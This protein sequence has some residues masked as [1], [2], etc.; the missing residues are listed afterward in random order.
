MELNYLREFIVLSET[1]NFLAASE[2]LFIS[3]STLS[4]HIQAIESELGAPLFIRTTRKI[5]LSDFGSRFLPYAKEIIKT[6]DSYTADLLIELR[7]DKQVIIGFGGAMSPYNIANIFSR[8]KSENPDIMLEVIHPTG[9]LESLRSNEC[10]FLLSSEAFVPKNEFDSIV[11]LDDILVAV[12]PN[13]H[14]LAGERCIDIKEL[15]NEKLLLMKSNAF[16]GSEFIMACSAA[17]FTPRYETTDGTNMIDFAALE[18]NVPIMTK[19]PAIFFADAS[20]SVLE[21]R[22]AVSQRS[23]IAY[24][25][26]PKLSKSERRFLEY[27]KSIPPEEKTINHF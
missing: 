26:F 13:T 8:F 1:M 15:E 9:M 11:F 25:R 7:R 19:Q 23:L 18:Q 4:R 24:R 27:L 21:I 10:D 5:E 16:E 17:G 6:Q 12:V 14:R 3:Q 20:V 22:P 2:K